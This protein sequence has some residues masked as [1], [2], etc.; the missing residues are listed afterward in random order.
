[1]IETSNASHKTKR[2][3]DN[4]EECMVC[5]EKMGSSQ[6]DYWN[7]HRMA[8]CSHSICVDCATKLQSMSD[9]SDYTMSSDDTINTDEDFEE[10]EYYDGMRI[11][12]MIPRQLEQDFQEIPVQTQDFP[13]DYTVKYSMEGCTF[14]RVNYFVLQGFQNPMQCPYCRQR[15]PTIYDFDG[16][17]YCVPSNTTEWN[18]LERK[19]YIDRVSSFTMSKEG[20]TFAFKLS[21]DESSLRVMWTEVNTYPFTSPKQKTHTYSD[22]KKMPKKQKDVRAYSRPKQYTKMIR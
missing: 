6:K 12:T 20:Q 3:M 22:F 15:E 13:V 17:R 4:T 14:T 9:E 5:F 21:K 11:H 1:M 8:S 18:I 2:K 19:L 10:I 16:L 7:I